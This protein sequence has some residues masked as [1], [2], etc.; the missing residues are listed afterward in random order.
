VSWRPA[1]TA[2]RGGRALSLL[3]ENALAAG[4]AAAALLTMGWLGLYGWAWTDWDTEAR[5][6]VDAL[7]AGHVGRFLHLAPAYGGSLILR[8]PF[9]LLT[10]LWHGGE[11]AI[12]RAGAAPCLLA[13]GALGVWLCARLRATGRPAGTRALALALCV[14]NPLTLSALQLG[15]PE[16]LLGAVLCVAA[17]L[18]AIDDRPTWAALLVGLA[19]A[20]KEWA[21]LALGPV[22]VALPRARLR[23]LLMAGAVAGA[24]LTPLIIGASGGFTGQ[25]AASG[26]NTGTIFQPWQLWWFLGS[27]GHLV[28][29]LSGNAKVGYRVPPAWLGS[30]G[31]TLVIAVMLPL[32]L[33]YGRLRSGAARRPH[34]GALLL[35]ALL[36]ALR[37][38]LD[39][40]DTAYYAVP[41]LLAL[42]TWE[43]LSFNRPPALSLAA[44]FATWLIFDQSS[45]VTLTPS[46]DV[47]ALVFALVSVP[48]VVALIVALY[49][50]GISAVLR[51]RFFERVLTR[52][53]RWGPGPTR[54][55]GVGT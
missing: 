15:H 48:A 3:R 29:G 14:A 18:C 44:A 35:L 53:E 7:L 39:P 52:P 22:L 41:F 4:A 55:A 51:R 31:H 38:V 20:N 13:T 50:P 42:V 1:A 21:V 33:L 26:L 32:S 10:T 2:V 40:W 30:L 16:E 25:A 43:S 17:V 46:A 47:Q 23:T 6:A 8:A 19:I 54:E 36:L 24:V 9:V 49:A 28:R 27:H 37:C 45:V 34:N 11:L 5:P 12:Y